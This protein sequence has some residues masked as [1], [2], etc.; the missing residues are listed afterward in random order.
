MISLNIVNMNLC[1]NCSANVLLQNHIRLE[2]K[3]FG[4]QCEVSK[5]KELF[6]KCK[7]IPKNSIKSFTEDK[8]EYTSAKHQMVETN[9]YMNS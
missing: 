7:D 1:T 2:A 5:N 8:N 6:I 3:I 4:H 9:S